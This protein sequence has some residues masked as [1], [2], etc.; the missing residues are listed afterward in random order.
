LDAVTKISPYIWQFSLPFQGEPGIIGPYL[1][2]GNAEIAVIDPGPHTTQEALLTAIRDAGFAPQDVTHL[3][4]THIHLDHAGAVGTLQEHMP[5]AKVYVH[6]KGAP[7]L[8]NPTKFLASATRIYGEKMQELW[9]DFKPVEQEKI[10]VI[11]DGEVINVAGR[12]LEVHYTPGHAIH[13]VVFFDVHSGELFAGDIAG[14]RLQGIDYVRPPTPP[15]DLDLEAWSTSLDKIKS[16]HPDVLYLAHFGPT[17][18]PTHHIERLREKLITWGSFIQ[19]A[20]NDNKSEA[21][22]IELLKKHTEPELLHIAGGDTRVL[23]GYDLAT[24]YPM[25]VQGYI[26]YWKKHERTKVV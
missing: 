4:L 21:E 9:G 2:A 25:T 20:T 5:K 8:I 22:I 15:P 1:L 12:R 10:Q 13:H 7:H 16:L 24:N 6:S 14:V 26:R 23:R 3:I 18:N 11:E 17:N 19:G